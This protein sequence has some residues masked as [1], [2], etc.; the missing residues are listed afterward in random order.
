[1]GKAV[2]RNCQLSILVDLPYFYQGNMN[3]Y[4]IG[5]SSSSVSNSCVRS[6]AG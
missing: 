6:A 1:M 3:E 5:S 2:F 4:I